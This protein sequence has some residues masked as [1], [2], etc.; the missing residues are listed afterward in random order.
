MFMS[1]LIFNVRRAAFAVYYLIFSGEFPFH[2][3]DRAATVQCEII[4]LELPDPPRPCAALI[5]RYIRFS[6]SDALLSPPFF[7]RSFRRWEWLTLRRAT[8]RYRRE[9]FE[10]FQGTESH[11]R[12]CH[13]S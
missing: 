1:T 5:L 10:L 4:A 9:A 2:T 13:P 6:A 12:A 3:E 11:A 7:V 8:A